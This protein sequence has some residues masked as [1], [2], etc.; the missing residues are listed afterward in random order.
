MHDI[1]DTASLTLTQAGALYRIQFSTRVDGR[2]E[3][4][5]TAQVDGITVAHRT[6]PSKT[7]VEAVVLWRN[8]RKQGWT[9]QD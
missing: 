1:I 4:R 3:L 7:A 2:V 5:E 8:L 6:Q 9:P